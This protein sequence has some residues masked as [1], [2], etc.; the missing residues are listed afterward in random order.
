MRKSSKTRPRR[1]AQPGASLCASILGPRGWLP[2]PAS[3]SRP[4]C[5]TSEIAKRPGCRRWLICA[6]RARPTSAPAHG[7]R[8]LRQSE[9][10]ERCRSGARAPPASRRC[11]TASPATGCAVSL[12]RA[13]THSPA[14]RAARLV[15]Q[16]DYCKREASAPA[17]A[18]PVPLQ[19]KRRDGLRMLGGSAG[20][21]TKQTAPCAPLSGQRRR[22]EHV[23]NWGLIG[24]RAH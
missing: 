8:G 14:G 22:G 24:R 17:F 21:C 19:S 16:I 1:L 13:S 10:G 12:S 6:P 4:R 15:L 7:S 18:R 5:H 2:P 9:V 20:G 3:G 11:L 23:P